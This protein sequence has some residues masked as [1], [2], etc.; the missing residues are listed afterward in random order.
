MP[1]HSTVLTN[2][3]NEAG[4]HGCTEIQRALQRLE[5][6]A[7]HAT[8]EDHPTEHL[9]Y[10]DVLGGTQELDMHYVCTAYHI[11][12]D[13]LD[14]HE[15][16]YYVGPHGEVVVAKWPAGRSARG[17]CVARQIDFRIK[18]LGGLRARAD[19]G[20]TSAKGELGDLAEIALEIVWSEQLV[21]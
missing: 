3:A 15:V 10:C 7:R 21:S 8:E 6:V 18:D 19:A 12:T 1:I 13:T 11:D 9:T 14:H 2:S 16:A 5:N 4:R 20:D 17:S